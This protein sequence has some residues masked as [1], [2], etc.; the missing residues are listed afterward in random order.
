M[1]QGT[2]GSA[3]IHPLYIKLIVYDIVIDVQM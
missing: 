1:G 2:N 3:N